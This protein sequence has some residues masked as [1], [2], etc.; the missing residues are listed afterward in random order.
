[1]RA[2]LSKKC[3]LIK[4]VYKKTSEWLSSPTHPITRSR[5]LVER[6]KEKEK[7]KKVV[8]L[9]RKVPHSKL[10]FFYDTTTF[11]VSPSPALVKKM[12]WDIWEDFIT[13]VKDAAVSQEIVKVGSPSP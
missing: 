3:R 4:K 5:A 13:F 12:Q 6:E 11:S 10:P 2:P 8:E 7:E 9:K 1:M